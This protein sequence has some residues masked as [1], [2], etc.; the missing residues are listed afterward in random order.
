[1]AVHGGTMTKTSIQHSLL[2]QQCA[3]TI[4]I[5]LRLCG[6]LLLVHALSSTSTRAEEQAIAPYFEVLQSAGEDAPASERLPLKAMH[7]DV[8]INGGIASVILKQRFGNNGTKPIE[9]RY[10]FP[11]ST[12]AAVHHMEMRVGERII[13]AI[14]KEKVEAK[15]IYE[16]AKEENK[17]A[18]LLEQQRPNVFQMSVANIMPGDDIEVT[19]HYSERIT[20]TASI[21]TFVLPGVVGPRYHSPDQSTNGA[22]WVSNPYLTPEDTG[23]P[24]TTLDYRVNVMLSTPL[25]LK[26]LSCDTHQNSVE[27]VDERNVKIKLQREPGDDA[28]DRD[29]IVRYRMADEKIATGLSLGDEI[30]GEKFFALQIEPPTRV[31]PDSI[32]PREYIFVVDVSGSMNGFPLNTAKRMLDKLVGNLRPQDRFNLLLF[33][34]SN[35]V[36]SPHSLPATNNNIDKAKRLI[37]RSGGGGTELLPA[38]KKAYSLG[39]DE[40]ISRS[41]VILTD[42][43]VSCEAEAFELIREQLGNANLFAFGIGSSVNRHLIEGLAAT[44]R[45][46]PFVVTDPVQCEAKAAEF[47]EYVSSPVLTD[48]KVRF[49]GF[50]AYANEPQAQPDLFADRPLVITGK[51][52]GAPVGTIHIDGKLGDGSPYQHTFEI[53]DEVIEKSSIDEPL[54]ILWARER[55]R[56]LADYALLTETSEAKREVTSLGLTYSLVTPFTSFVAVMDETRH[57]G[58]SPGETVN[59]PLP[60]PKGVTSNAVGGGHLGGGSVPEPS[61]IFLLLIGGLS[62]LWS[63]LSAR[64]R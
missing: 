51:W 57:H 29:F 54:R 1:M 52:R 23:Q 12:G 28:S 22:Q 40:G 46:E 13:N 20:P 31:T 53:N 10:L 50:D 11:A 58:D 35:R 26:D 4:N 45:G 9:A 59:Q 33:A 43:Y 32:T 2:V 30:E 61:S 55:V 27:Y 38:L 15:A 60:L 49:D 5:A 18:S 24:D 47:N 17:T 21:Y 3:R 36:L 14:I 16:K 37:D 41:I 42:G 62:L 6:I 56:A 63:R 19:L 44:G 48:I 8:T 25:P 34:S 7:A 39:G 64:N